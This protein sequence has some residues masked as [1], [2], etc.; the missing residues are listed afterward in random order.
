MEL[1]RFD[2]RRFNTNPD[3]RYVYSASINNQHRR[4]FYNQLAKVDIQSGQTSTWYSEE[5]Y[6][7]E[8]IFVGR[9]DRTEEDDGV[10]LSVVLDAAAGTSFLLVLDASSFT[11]IGRA[12][13][14]HP[15][16]FGYHGEYF[17]QV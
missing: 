17:N 13:I 16:L 11:E 1:P 8:P 7:G 3:Y 12:E 14:P 2:Y 5:C 9:P 10:V 15:I 6:P 4:G